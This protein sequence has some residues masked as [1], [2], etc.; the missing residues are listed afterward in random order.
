MKKILSALFGCLGVFLSV[1]AY[2]DD[3]KTCK[4]KGTDGSVEVSVMVTNADQGICIV[5]FSNDTDRNVNVRYVISCGNKSQQGSV[6]VYANSES[7]KQVAFNQTVIASSVKI[8][9][10]TGEKCE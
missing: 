8:S 10:L 9:T 2:A 3:T 1:S 4:V 5:S 7:T 6:L